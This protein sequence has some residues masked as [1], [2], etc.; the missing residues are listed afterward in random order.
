MNE[1]DE[2]PTNLFGCVRTERR[3]FAETDGDEVQKGQLLGSDKDAKCSEKNPSFVSLLQLSLEVGTTGGS[4]GLR[5]NKLYS[6]YMRWGSKSGGEAF[7]GH[8]NALGC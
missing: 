5:S 8:K 3:D 6:G 4:N 2:K 1:C 7:G